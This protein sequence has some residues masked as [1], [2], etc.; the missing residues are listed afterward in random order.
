MT[1]CC[2]LD[3]DERTAADGIAG[4]NAAADPARSVMIA[5]E[6]FM[7]LSKWLQLQ[8]S[9]S[10]SVVSVRWKVEVEKSLRDGGNRLFLTHSSFFALAHQW[11]DVHSSLRNYKSG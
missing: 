5:A 2:W 4:A 6:S 11:T 7:L 1:V 10:S 8:I 9:S 3:D